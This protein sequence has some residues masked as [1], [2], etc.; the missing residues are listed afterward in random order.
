M[1]HSTEKIE[2]MSAEQVRAK[3]EASR[4]DGESFTAAAQRM[5]GELKISRRVLF[6]W[7]KNGIVLKVP[8]PMQKFMDG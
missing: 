2:L 3:I 1:K 7:L 5:V 8:L 6:N 4:R